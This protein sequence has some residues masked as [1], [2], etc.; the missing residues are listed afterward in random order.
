MRRVDLAGSAAA[1]GPSASNPSGLTAGAIAALPAGLNGELEGAGSPAEQEINAARAPRFAAAQ[2]ESGSDLAALGP[3]RVP[4]AGPHPGS[5]G[6]GGAATT[7]PLPAFGTEAAEAELA[8]APSE[9]AESGPRAHQGVDAFAD[10]SAPAADLSGPT[11]D[12]AAPPQASPVQPLTLGE[13]S[14]TGRADALAQ[15]G[16]GDREP[17][18]FGW[19]RGL[20]GAGT[21]VGQDV[22]ASA[23]VVPPAE[24]VAH[25]NRL[26]IFE[27]VESDW[28]RRGRSGVPAAP[29]AA[30]QAAAATLGGPTGPVR[31]DPVAGVGASLGGSS[32]SWPADQLAGRTEPEVTWAASAADE[33]W[34]AAAAASSPATGGTTT[35]GLPKRVPQANLVPG[36]ASPEPAASVPV[37][38][39]AA[40]RDRFASFQRGIREGRAV[41]SG[42]D[43]HSDEDDGSR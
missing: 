27:A 34:H 31:P 39:A 40:T 12:F 1:F 30:G 13:P 25:E 7:S 14:V 15:P 10:A 33:G 17:A 2:A 21:P 29:A 11:V 8:G 18:G 24:H 16:T 22:S 35:A 26:P 4:G 23:V 38:S 43:G 6:W 3:R 42:D 36:T 19:D 32:G 28:F 41:A 5:V 37:R 20:V 9:R